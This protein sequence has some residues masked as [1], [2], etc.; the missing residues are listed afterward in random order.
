MELFETYGNDIFV[1]SNLGEKF[2]RFGLLGWQ[3]NPLG[4]KTAIIDGVE[5]SVNT[6]QLINLIKD[7]TLMVYQGSINTALAGWNNRGRPWDLGKASLGTAS[8]IG[9]MVF[10][11]VYRPLWRFLKSLFNPDDE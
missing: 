9:G 3:S 10:M 5:V 4:T 1:F 2:G 11:F 7:E 6:N 8:Q